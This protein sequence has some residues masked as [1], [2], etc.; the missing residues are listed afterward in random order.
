MDIKCIETIKVA[1]I[2]KLILQPVVE[3]SII[4]GL[5]QK[6]GNG[7]LTID[8]SQLGDIIIIS[9]EDDGVGFD[10]NKIEFKNTGFGMKNVDRRIKI[11]FGEEYGLS[12]D[13]NPS[14]GTC[15]IIVLPLILS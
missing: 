10:K 14:K 9:I 6:I 3:N 5:E 7:H 4:H 1:K 15:V 2:P 13:S 8:I 11:L 12:I